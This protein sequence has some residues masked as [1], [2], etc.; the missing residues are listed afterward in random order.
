MRFQS[1]DEGGYEQPPGIAIRLAAEAP[2]QRTA[3]LERALGFVIGRIE[4]EA[5]R[6]EQPL[7]EEQWLLLNNLPKHSAMP[8]TSAAFEEYPAVIVP[9]DNTYE[10]LCAVTKCAHDNDLR[11]NTASALDWEFAAAVSKLNRH[12]MSWLLQWAGVNESRPWWDRWL[13]IAAA[14]LVITFGAALMLLAENGPWTRF[15]LAG[16]G[17]GYAAILLLSVFAARRIEDWE[18]KQTI[19]KCRRGS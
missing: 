6:S 7:S 17:A 5:T 10:R 18:L 13:L 9:R 8:Q 14:L 16:I 12:P 3:D 19:E 11:Q 1:Y 4:E 2:V 15:Q